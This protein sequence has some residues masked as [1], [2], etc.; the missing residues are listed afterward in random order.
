[1]SSSSNTVEARFKRNLKI[2]FNEDSD[3]LAELIQMIEASSKKVII[4]WAHEQA[5]KACDLFMK[6]YP[7]EM[8]PLFAIEQ[9]IMWSQGMIKMGPAKQAILACHAVAK[10]LENK[11]D[12]AIVHAIGQAASTVHVKSHALGLVFYELSSI[13][14]DVGIEQYKDP[15]IQKIDEYIIRLNYWNNAVHKVEHSWVSFLE[16]K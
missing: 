4:K 7:L 5:E 2:L 6:N 12:I 11:K 9:S 10:E 3:C 14:F 16:N 1:M 15:V 13:V 8:R